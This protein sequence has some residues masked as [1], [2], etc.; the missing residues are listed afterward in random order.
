MSKKAFVSG[1]PIII[2]ALATIG[3]L[4]AFVNMGIH[5]EAREVKDL[6]REELLLPSVS[7][8]DRDRVISDVQ[9]A[10]EAFYGKKLLNAE[11][12]GSWD[13]EGLE[14]DVIDVAFMTQ[15]RNS[16][17]IASVDP[18]TKQIIAIETVADEG[19]QIANTD[20]QMEYVA[21]AETILEEQ[22]NITKP[23]SWICRLPAP[24]GNESSKSVYVF[25]PEIFMYVEISASSDLHLVGYRCFDTAEQANEFMMSQSNAF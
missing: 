21:A 2:V 1:L 14:R 19:D 15:E 3:M 5:A 25:F 13:A 20:R 12:Y 23:G 16:P 6:T 8:L 10:M 11:I 17:Y 7:S 4:F 24:N 22:M 9:T 18:Q